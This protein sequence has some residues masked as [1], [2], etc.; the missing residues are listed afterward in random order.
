[1]NLLKFDDCEI[2]EAMFNPPDRVPI[3]KAFKEFFELVKEVEETQKRKVITKNGR[4]VVAIT[5]LNESAFYESARLNTK[6]K[7]GDGGQ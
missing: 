6:E 3:S 4:A 5:P 7:E 1:M 2:A